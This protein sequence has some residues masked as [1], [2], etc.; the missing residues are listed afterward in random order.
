M[1]RNPINISLRQK[2]GVFGGDRQVDLAG[3]ELEVKERGESV[4]KRT[5]SDGEAQR[6]DD[7]AQRLISKGPPQDASDGFGY[8]DSILTEVD[9]GDATEQRTY[10]VRSGD[11][12]PDELW[13]LVGTIS[14]IA[15][16]P[17]SA[18]TPLPGEAPTK[19]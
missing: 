18:P 7:I 2:G 5:L 8:S 16:A 3:S 11:N 12:A 9:I 19:S 13:E 15:D 6:L 10:R 1:D 14:E 4:T 17:P